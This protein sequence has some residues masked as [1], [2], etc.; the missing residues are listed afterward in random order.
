MKTF[1]ILWL[2]QLF[3]SVGSAMTYFTLTLWVWQ[4]TESASAIAFIL[5]F[6]QLPQ[7]IIVVEVF[8]LVFWGLVLVCLWWLWLLCLVCGFCFDLLGYFIIL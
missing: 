3:S 1:I 7:L 4:K 5:V 2:G 8:L 6:Y